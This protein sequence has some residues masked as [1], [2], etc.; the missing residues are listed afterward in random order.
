[1]IPQRWILMHQF[2]V[3]EDIGVGKY[4]KENGI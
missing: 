3:D 2:L 1:M 4:Q